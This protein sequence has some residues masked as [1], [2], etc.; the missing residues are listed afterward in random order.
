MLCN[1]DVW[2]DAH[3]PL[4]CNA[5]SLQNMYYSFNYLKIEIMSGIAI[6]NFIK[7]SEHMNYFTDLENAVG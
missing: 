4:D 5:L 1:S 7:S 6:K 3:F 2:K